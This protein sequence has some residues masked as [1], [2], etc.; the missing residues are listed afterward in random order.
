MDFQIVFVCGVTTDHKITLL[1]L[2][3]T[4]T[5]MYTAESAKSFSAANEAVA[6]LILQT[7]PF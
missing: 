2:A 6:H 4:Y 3:Q 5:S 7:S 1:L